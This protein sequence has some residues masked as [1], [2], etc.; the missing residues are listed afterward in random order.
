M[1]LNT[2]VEFI[3]IYYSGQQEIFCT[4]GGN[5]ILSILEHCLFDKRN[6]GSGPL[7][8]EYYKISI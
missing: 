7:T 2:L 8:L 6:K 5:A 3:P 1:N 4:F